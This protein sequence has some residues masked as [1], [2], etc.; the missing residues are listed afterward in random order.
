MFALP[1]F[2]LKPPAS[3]SQTA[4]GASPA[5]SV[6]R[7][8]QPEVA[9]ELQVYAAPGRR[10]QLPRQQQ[11]AGVGVGVAR[12][13]DGSPRRRYGDVFL[14]AVQVCGEAICCQL[15]VTANQLQTE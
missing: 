2:L 5:R 9:V 14:L 10:E 8:L 7:L 11:V 6:L 12:A 4:V 3:V 15:A 1:S 13:V